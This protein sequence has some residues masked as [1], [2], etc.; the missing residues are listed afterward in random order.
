MEGKKDYQN[1]QNF[2]K[3]IDFCG[4]KNDGRSVASDLNRER[5][6]RTTKSTILPN[7]KASAR[8]T[9]SAAEN[10]R[11]EVIRGKGENVR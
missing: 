11:H 10:N 9:D 7:R 1:Y 5:K 3:N 2:K 4:L 8:A 6:V